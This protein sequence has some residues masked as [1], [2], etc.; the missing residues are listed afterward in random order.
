[1]SETATKP[2][3]GAPKLLAEYDCNA[4]KRQLIG[5]RVNGSVHV[6]D[7]PQGEEGRV[8]LVE[9]RVGSMK[10]LDALV[11]D[12]LDKAARLG[13]CPMESAEW[14]GEL[15]LSRWLGQSAPATISA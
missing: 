15:V 2:A 9:R 6:T 12:Y 8:Y 13:R 3:T 11:A 14:W 4:G 1:M 7:V 10:E 5:A